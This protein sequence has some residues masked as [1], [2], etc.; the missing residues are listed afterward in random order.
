MTRKLLL[1][2]QPTPGLRVTVWRKGEL[3]FDGPCIAVHG[4]VDS[5]YWQ[6]WGTATQIAPEL[7]DEW[8]PNP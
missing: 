3:L 1:H 5:I 7:M 4:E 6:D 8:E 2:E